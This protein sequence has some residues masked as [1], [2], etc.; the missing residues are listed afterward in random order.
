MSTASLL[1]FGMDVLV[2][3]VALLVFVRSERTRLGMVERWLPLLAVLIIG[4]S[5]GLPLFLY[6]R[7]RKLKQEQ[8]GLLTKTATA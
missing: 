6:M 1:L 3:A 7:E 8:E 4:V 2:S 5:L